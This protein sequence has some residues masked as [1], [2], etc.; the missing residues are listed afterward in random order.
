MSL[1]TPGTDP[2]C[3][4]CQTERE[5]FHHFIKE[6]PRLRSYRAQ[7]FN[8]YEGPT[9]PDWKP[10]DLLK[11]SRLQEISA[12]IDFYDWTEEKDSDIF[13][14]SGDDEINE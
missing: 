9:L 8:H 10:E 1:T 2:M 12:A 13:M 11:F 3:R 5:T 14:S 4:F 7:C 6:C